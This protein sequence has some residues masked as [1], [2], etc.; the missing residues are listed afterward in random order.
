V[1]GPKDREAIAGRKT[2]YFINGLS[3]ESKNTPKVGRTEESSCSGNETLASSQT[4]RGSRSAG[5]KNEG[6]RGLEGKNND[7]FGETTTRG[8]RGKRF[9]RRCF[10]PKRRRMKSRHID[11]QKKR[12]KKRDP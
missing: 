11:T 1:R 10:R 3:A 2:F 5:R 6:N 4:A 12:S 7:I 8:L 9:R